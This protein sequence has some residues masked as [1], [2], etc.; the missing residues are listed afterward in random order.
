MWNGTNSKWKWKTLLP[1]CS[2]SSC[3][4]DSSANRFQFTRSHM[5]GERKREEQAK[6]KS[7]TDATESDSKCDELNEVNFSFAVTLNCIVV[8]ILAFSFLL[9]FFYCFQI[10]EI[11][12]VLFFLLASVRLSD[13]PF[14]TF[15]V[16]EVLFLFSLALRLNGNRELIEGRQKFNT[17][18]FNGIVLFLGSCVWQPSQCVHCLLRNL[19]TSFA[20]SYSLPWKVHAEMR[21]WIILFMFI[22]II[23]RLSSQITMVL[24]LFGCCCRCCRCF[25]ISIFTIYCRRRHNSC[26]RSFIDCVCISEWHKKANERARDKTKNWISVFHVLFGS[27]CVSRKRYNLRFKHKE[28]VCWTKDR[29]LLATAACRTCRSLSFVAQAICFFCERESCKK[30]RKNPTKKLMNFAEK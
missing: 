4:L 29:F 16:I 8:W 9:L 6:D 26:A 28:K 2:H 11:F 25:S 5:K 23:L 17:F 21:V 12:S 15:L 18:F 30:E 13:C 24:C 14:C 1:L 20:F 22:F 19:F 10:A 7:K 27:L 3:Q